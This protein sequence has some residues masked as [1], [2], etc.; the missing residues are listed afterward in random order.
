M[1]DDMR[2]INLDS[3]HIPPPFP[4]HEGARNRRT[5]YGFHLTRAKTPGMIESWRRVQKKELPVTEDQLLEEI[6]K[7]KENGVSAL[8]IYAHD[9]MD[10][11]KRDYVDRLIRDMTLHD[12]GFEYKLA[13]LKLK[14]GRDAK[15]HRVTALMRVILKRQRAAEGPRTGFQG[16]DGQTVDINED[17]QD[18]QHFARPLNI[19]FAP[20]SFAFDQA[21]RIAADRPD[22]QIPASR[23]VCFTPPHGASQA[24]QFTPPSDGYTPPP[25]GHTPPPPGFFPPRPGHHI[26]PQPDRQ[27]PESHNGPV[28]HHG[29]S[30]NFYNRP[31]EI[32]R[33]EEFHGGA[34]PEQAKKPRKKDGN[35]KAGDQHSKGNQAKKEKRDLHAYPSVLDSEDS[36]NSL[37]DDSLFSMTGT[38]RTGDTEDSDHRREKRYS[39]DG[40]GSFRRSLERDHVDFDR[41]DHRDH[42]PRRRESHRDSRGSHDFNAIR[43]N[44]R[45]SP[46]RSSNSSTSSGS[47]YLHDEKIYIPNSQRARRGS[48]YYSLDE[49]PTFHSHDNSYE[50]VRAPRRPSTYRGKRL[51]V[52]NPPVELY[53]ERD[54][55]EKA[56]RA[57]VKHEMDK[58]VVEDL[59]RD[60][61]RL[62]EEQR[63]R[64]EPSMNERERVPRVPATDLPRSRRLS[65][66]LQSN[67]Y[68][69]GY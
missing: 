66:D 32:H 28:P 59:R 46:P 57:Q 9:D 37:S 51:S 33:S 17:L 54:E 61:D 27:I 34:P 26:H 63:Y 25:H 40:Y 16:V 8:K 13:L 36:D 22:M 35:A 53:D 67:R 45:K 6:I 5:L 38:N 43:Q 41:A 65:A 14:F 69:H 39:G 68:H 55:I 7:E 3:A 12:P 21:G 62:K 47:R 50:E 30:P 10:G 31:E 15:G 58:K 56:V 4:S 1:A 19:P 29:E 44:R 52:Y 42:V 11:L 60:V 2:R 20:P 64:P 48:E 23:P 49:R 24:N 18:Q